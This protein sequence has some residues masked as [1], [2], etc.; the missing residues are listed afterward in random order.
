MLHVSLGH[1]AQEK[2]RTFI[3]IALVLLE[4]LLVT[5]ALVPAQKWTQL[6]PGSPD[7]AQNGPFPHS[8]AIIV[9]ILLY[10][11]PTLVGFLC[12]SWQ[13]ALFYATLP[14][15]IGLGLFVTAASSKLGIFNLVSADSVTGNVSLLELFA[16]LGGMGWLAQYVFQSRS[17]QS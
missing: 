10:L 7:A 13:R 15:W 4:T 3:I 5:M 2:R 12:R 6:L 11:I 1:T 8:I 17:S 16:A 9:P 14:A